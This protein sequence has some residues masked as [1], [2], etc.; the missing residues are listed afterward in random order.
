MQKDV[1]SC[2][3]NFCTA[4]FEAGLNKGLITSELT[5]CNNF[6]YIHFLYNK[7]TISKT[8]QKHLTSGFQIKE[9]DSPK[10]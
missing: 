5:T 6:V 8:Y 7:M 10:F 2:S 1:T 9:Q 3:D 4:Y